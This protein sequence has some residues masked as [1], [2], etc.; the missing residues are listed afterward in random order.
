M[1]YFHTRPTPARR[2]APFRER[3]QGVHDVMKKERHTCARRRGGE[4]RFL[5]VKRI[6]FTRPPRACRDRL[7]SR[8]GTLRV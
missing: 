6:Y 3:P 5:I 1:A 7:F 4:P 8:E 2:D